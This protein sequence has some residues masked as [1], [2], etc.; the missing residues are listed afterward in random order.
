MLQG[1]LHGLREFFHGFRQGI[2]LNRSLN[3]QGAIRRHELGL[4]NKQQGP[5]GISR[6]IGF[7]RGKH[8]DGTD[9]QVGKEIFAI[10]IVLAELDFVQRFS[11]KIIHKSFPLF[12]SFILVQ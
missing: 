12:P 6:A 7:Y 2:C 8:T 3:G 9:A 11:G 1:A 5:A 10:E 4:S